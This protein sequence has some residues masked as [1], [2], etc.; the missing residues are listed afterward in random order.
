MHLNSKQIPYVSKFP[1]SSAFV[2]LPDFR[3][4]LVFRDFEVSSP[5]LEA[6]V[7]KIL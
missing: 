3:D 7:K 1:W 2:I 6:A 4:S 5:V